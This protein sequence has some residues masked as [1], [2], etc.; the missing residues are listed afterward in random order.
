MSHPDFEKLMS[1]AKD[2]ASIDADARAVEIGGPFDG[3]INSIYKLKYEVSGSE[4]LLI[5]R[6]RIS[7]A[8]RY[9]GIVKEKL[10]FPILTNELR[11]MNNPSLK[12]D[13]KE[14]VDRKSGSFIVEEHG[15]PVVP[16]QNIYYFDETME[17]IPYIYTVLD[18]VP[19]ISLYE[20]IEKNEIKGKSLDSLDKDKRRILE[21][22]FFQAGA[23]LG[24]MHDI[25]FPAFY[26][27]I[28]DIGDRTKEIKWKDLFLLRVRDLMN[29]ASKYKV[30]QPMIQPLKRFFQERA[31]ILTDNE[32]PVLFHNDYQSQNFI[33]DELTGHINAII[34][35]DNWEVGTKEQD[36]IKIQY[37][38]L[39]NLDPRLESLFMNGYKK[40]QKIADDFQ[41]KVDLYKVAWFI[42]VFNFETDKI[43]KN[44]RNK[45]VD[46]RF[47]SAEKYIQ[48]I[49]Q[50]IKD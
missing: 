48:E 19:G 33:I 40:H 31:H 6:A 45:E 18:Y 44:E 34:D 2:A 15:K 27:N 8:F 11:T 17:K 20:F 22:A 49:K 46:S 25:K 26:E 29:E 37:W 16:I 24:R 50:I 12:V 3:K 35:F 36:F 4:K 14:L 7:G 30:F 1:M 28:L 10:L 41:S 21:N 9:E 39:K 5:F 13:I 42:L 47:P 38:G 23:F 32:T 43:L